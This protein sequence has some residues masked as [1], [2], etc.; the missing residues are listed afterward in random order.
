VGVGQHT[1]RFPRKVAACYADEISRRRACA[2]LCGR[3]ERA[4]RPDRLVLH[5]QV[6]VVAAATWKGRVQRRPS[7][8]GRAQHTPALLYQRFLPAA[9]AADGALVRDCRRRRQIKS[10]RCEPRC[11]RVARPPGDVRSYPLGGRP[12]TSAAAA[13]HAKIT[14]PPSSRSTSSQGSH[15][16]SGSGVSHFLS[17]RRLARRARARANLRA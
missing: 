13:N 14:T 12:P 11:V 17:R 15:P 1:R 3:P 4:A 7:A 2:L 5:P 10:N 16:I 9:V 8:T 6:A